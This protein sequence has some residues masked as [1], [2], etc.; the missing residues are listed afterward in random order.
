MSRRGRAAASTIGLLLALAGEAGGQVAGPL[1]RLKTPSGLAAGDRFGATVAVKDDQIAIG[2][3]LAG[4]GAGAVY[5]YEKTN[6]DWTLT[7]VLRGKAGEQFGFSLAF[8]GNDLLVGAPFAVGGGGVRCGLVYSISYW[9]MTPL[10]LPCEEGAEMGTA[11]AAA[12]SSIVVGAR[13]AAQRA[14]RVYV[15]K[16]E[17]GPFQPL[18]DTVAQPGD[19]LG[20]SVATDGDLVVAGAPF[21]KVA[22]L[23]FVFSGNGGQALSPPSAV[24]QDAFGYAVAISGP[25]I[26]VG[27][28]L[29]SGGAGAVH[30]FKLSG[31]ENGM[32]SGVSPGGQLGVALAFAGSELFAGARRDGGGGVAKSGAV[33]PVTNLDRQ[34]E[35]GTPID[36]PAP[37]AGAEFGFDLA[38]IPNLLV[39]GAFGEGGTGAA[40]VTAEGSAVVQLATAANSVGE[41]DGTIGITVVVDPPTHPSG[42]TVFLTTANGTAQAGIDYQGITRQA[43]TIPSGQ[44]TATLTIPIFSD[45]A[46]T[47]DKTFTV[48]LTAP[49]PSVSLGSPKTETVTI[50]D[51][52]AVLLTPSPLAF[53]ENGD[54]VPLTVQ[55]T[56]PPTG[57]VKVALE[58]SRLNVTPVILTFPAGSMAPQQ[59]LVAAGDC[60]ANPSY[61][62]TA[63]VKRSLDPRYTPDHPGETLAE[64]VSAAQSSFVAP[65][66]TAL[67]TVLLSNHGPLAAVFDYVVPL[68]G[69]SPVWAGA[70]SGVA[71][72]DFEA[73]GV[74]WNGNLPPAAEGP[75]AIHVTAAPA[76]P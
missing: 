37:V 55:L 35:M 23:A 29:A 67:T 71:Q 61:A 15:G 66:G 4:N 19:E 62:I 65:D 43:V 39:V 6:G 64:C 51:T 8:S 27:A 74:L 12:G 75:V 16:T 68:S 36:S 70:D 33:Y 22:G 38:G 56:C 28:P 7:G 1:T 59:V 5:L 49:S 26:A 3:Y 25:W 30:V 31:A 45:G 18:G 32:V 63:R 21:A 48:S 60:A 10:G 72:V 11:V 14:G 54:P 69:L 73:N 76:P 47:G 53:L 46:C 2:A 50:H 17:N 40:Y 9:M 13:G 58:S 42:V 52:P 34:P 44:K 24:A 20:T 57:Q 41:G